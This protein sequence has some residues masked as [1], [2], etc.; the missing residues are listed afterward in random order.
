MSES[1]PQPQPR[2]QYPPFHQWATPTREPVAGLTD[3]KQRPPLPFKLLNP[4]LL[5]PL[6]YRLG[7]RQYASLQIQQ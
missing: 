4:A 7:L 6:P 1:Q 5:P 3:W 2:P